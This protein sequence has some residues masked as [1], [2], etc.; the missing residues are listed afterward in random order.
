LCDAVEVL[1]DA[2][3]VLFVD[4]AVLRDAVRETYNFALVST[5]S[6]GMRA[7]GTR[8]AILPAGRRRLT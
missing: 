7:R 1:C 6:S 4:V 2:D 8:E 5:L 3:E